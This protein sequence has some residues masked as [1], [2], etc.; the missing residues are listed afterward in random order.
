MKTPHGRPIPRSHRFPKAKG[1]A[2]ERRTKNAGWRH[3]LV[4]G[5]VSGALVAAASMLGQAALDDQRSSREE[6]LEN[7]RFVRERSS[8]ETAN[9]PFRGIDLKRQSLDGLRLAGA[10][11]SFAELGQTSFFSADLSKATLAFA[12]LEGSKFIVADLT[13]ADLNSAKLTHANL[14]SAN[15]AGADLSRRPRRGKSEIRESGRCP[16]QKCEFCRGKS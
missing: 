1:P 9:R 15:L 6:R 12:K 10:D 11:L 13:R 14:E 4:V 5:L 7:L 8:E 2:H 16:P 3:D